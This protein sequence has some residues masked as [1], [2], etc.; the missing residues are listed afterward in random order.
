[1]PNYKAKY[2]WEN[3]GSRTSTKA[4]FP[5]RFIDQHVTT[6]IFNKSIE[7]RSPATLIDMEFHSDEE[8]WKS[9]GRPLLS[10]NAIRLLNFRLIDWFPRAPGVYHSRHA[11][12]ARTMVWQ[13]EPQT[14]RV[15]GT[16]F[17]P[18]EKMSLIENGG[19]GT[20]RLRPRKID[21]ELCWLATALSGAKCHA[22]VPLAIPDSL[23]R[24]KVPKW[25][26]RFAIQGRVRFLQDLGLVEQAAV[27]RGARPLILF[28]EELLAVS[29]VPSS[30]RIAIAPVVLFE[31]PP[32]ARDWQYRQAEY[33][34]VNCDA[35]G[36]A[37]LDRAVEWIETYAKKFEGR[38]ITNFDE[39]RPT[40]ADAPLSYQRLV[41]GMYD[42]RIL[43]HFGG[44]IRAEHIE[45]V[46]MYN[47]EQNYGDKVMGHKITTHGPAIINIDTV[48]DRVTQ[49]IGA[50]NGLDLAQKRRLEPLVESLRNELEKL[51]VSH[52]DEATE[53]ATALDKAVANAV[54]SPE[55]RK[56][57]L[58][59]F[60]AD[61]LKKAAELVKGIA[62][63]VLETA[64]EVA[65][66]ISNL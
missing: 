41:K 9:E 54:K 20:V 56:R 28:V 26:D 43:D 66:F 10:A 33:T 19:V 22:G 55:E 48:L 63:T 62:P 23:I 40:L 57:N 35:G 8:F 29:A 2:P 61:G 47:V 50:P 53:I 18:V 44:T 60:S 34:F 45:R 42:K 64:R 38:L 30:D 39:Q 46:I 32:Q 36:D 1:M 49:N 65:D 16:Y 21:G 11:A 24:E 58:L 25:G 5:E 7:S 13:T 15:L 52:A 4:I 27:V 31:R 59:S 6:A 51:K 37:E 14:D 3:R 12:D 17:A